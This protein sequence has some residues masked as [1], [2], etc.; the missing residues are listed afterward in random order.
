MQAGSA[1]AFSLTFYLML[2]GH[3]A[4]DAYSALIPAILST[5]E[6][7]FQLDQHQSAWLLAAGTFSSGLSQPLFGWLSKRLHTV[8]FV[9]L[10]VFMAA[11]C[12]PTI[13]MISG[14]QSLYAHY[15]I[16][17]IG[18][19]IFH[20]VAASVIGC[21]QPEKRSIAISW[22]FVAGMGG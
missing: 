6:W 5:L 21:I 8:A 20:P 22:F 16:G 17:M 2:A 9:G 7:R 13:S 12:I 10:G 14:S 15:I 3:F 11:I 1:L 4:V 18:V 19:G